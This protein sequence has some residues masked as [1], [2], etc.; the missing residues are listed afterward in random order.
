MW[1]SASFDRNFGSRY[2]WKRAK[3]EVNKS[4]FPD[5]FE[6]GKVKS[7]LV[8]AI[9]STVVCLIVILII[10]VMR[11]RINLLVRLFKEAG[12]A[13]RK[14]PFLLLQ[15]LLVCTVPLNKQRI[16]NGLG[17]EKILLSFSWN[18]GPLIMFCFSPVFLGSRCNHWNLGRFHF[19]HSRL[20]LCC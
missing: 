4:E 7:Y 20:W 10:F 18:K 1:K 15:P 3:D 14:M 2:L 11:K 12:K 17:T 9:A 6:V 5:D 16:T 13:V 8:F 19:G